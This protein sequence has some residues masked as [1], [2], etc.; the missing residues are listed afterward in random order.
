MSENENSPDAPLNASNPSTNPS[1]MTNMSGLVNNKENEEN[2]G[3]N[4]GAVVGAVVKRSHHKTGR[5]LGCL[6]NE[7]KVMLRSLKQIWHKKQGI[8]KENTG[9]KGKKDG[10]GEAKGSD[11]IAAAQLFADLQGW[12]SKSSENT[13]KGEILK[14]EFIKDLPPP[15]NKMISNAPITKATSDALVPTDAN[16]PITDTNGPATPA[17]NITSEDE[18]AK[19]FDSLF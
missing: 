7:K 17:Q 2:K 14:I 10:K 1:N 6:E 11:V 16:R 9:K 18:F 15:S 5:P 8:F 3:E 12:R 13:T 4:K 19:A